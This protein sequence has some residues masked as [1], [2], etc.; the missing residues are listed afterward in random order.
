[1]TEHTVATREE[2]LTARKTLLEREREHLRLGDDVAR[3]RRELPWVRVEK[4]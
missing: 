1:M 3:Q 2:W 4:E